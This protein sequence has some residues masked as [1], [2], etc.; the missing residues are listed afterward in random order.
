MRK[1]LPMILSTVLC[2]G[3]ST[4]KPFQKMDRNA[5][6]AIDREEAAASA[7]VADMFSTADDDDSETLDAEE[8]DSVLRVID[9]YRQSTPR[10]SGG[11]GNVE[12][13][14]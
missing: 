13:G 12:V 4:I 6:G 7:Q 1:I 2:V 14:H 8:Y 9:Q 11:A 5:D 3:C 10:R